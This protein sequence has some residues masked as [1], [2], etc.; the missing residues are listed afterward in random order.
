MKSIKVVFVLFIAVFSSCNNV[1]K[2]ISE[3]EIIHTNLKQQFAPDKRVELFDI[4]FE[5]NKNQIILKGETTTKLAFAML[6]DSLKSRKLDFVNNVRVLPDSAVGNKIHALGNNSVINIRSTPAHSAELGT[7]GLLGMELKILDKKGSWYRIQTPDKY[8]SWVDGGGIEQLTTEELR[9][10]HKK[11]K[12]IYTQNSGYVYEQKEETSTRVSDISFGG[13]LAITKEHDLFYEVEYP[14]GRIGFLKKTEAVLYNSWLKNSPAS[15]DFIEASAKTMLGVPYLWG[16]TS[17]KG[18]DCSG[19]TKT[20]YLMNGFI[21]PRDASQ[22]VTAGK[23][24]DEELK[25]EGLEKGDLLFFGTP[26][27]GDK[28]MRVTHVG[29]WLGNGKG[30]FIHSA[31]NVHLSSINEN[32]KNYD[33]FNKKRYLGSRRYLGVKDDKIID[34]KASLQI[35]P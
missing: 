28:K 16:G 23:I 32:E 4:Q 5:V 6:L 33:G 9:A 19:F 35:L 34:M 24:V 7:Q 21:I 20:V 3:L 27:S 1:S 30:E 25:F 15:A 11:N 13:I 2:S 31:S 10:W 14:D 12:L 8:I 26:A 17:T 29:I 22:Q 18:N